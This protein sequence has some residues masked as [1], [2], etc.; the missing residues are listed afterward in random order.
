MGG[1]WLPFAGARVRML[2]QELAGADGARRGGREGLARVRHCTARGA[3]AG[4]GRAVPTAAGLC[5]STWAVLDPG[6]RPAS[7]SVQT[8]SPVDGRLMAVGFSG[9]SGGEN[10]CDLDPNRDPAS[11]CVIPRDQPPIIA[12]ARRGEERA[13]SHDPAILRGLRGQRILCSRV[14][15]PAA[16]PALAQRGESAHALSS[17]FCRQQK[18]Q[19]FGCNP[20]IACT[21]HPSLLFVRHQGQARK[22]LSRVPSKRPGA[23]LILDER[24]KSKH[25]RRRNGQPACPY[26]RAQPGSPRQPSLPANLVQ[27][28]NTAPFLSAP[29][30]SGR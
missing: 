13:F 3:V 11:S 20:S 24:R 26:P 10:G 21:L 1:A 29:T 9:L 16:Y 5:N 7:V 14:N 19:H 23:R 25:H 18:P 6:W 17:A 15:W 28:A 2:L 8:E 22:Q 30:P 27:G 12:R 4:G